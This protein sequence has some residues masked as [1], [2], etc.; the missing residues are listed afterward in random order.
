V[1]TAAFAVF[2]QNPSLHAVILLVVVEVHVTVAPLALFATSAQ[3]V[4]T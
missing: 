4:H 2:F 3:A 1:S